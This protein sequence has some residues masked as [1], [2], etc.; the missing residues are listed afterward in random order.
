MVDFEQNF[1]ACHSKS[2]ISSTVMTFYYCCPN[3]VFSSI[4]FLL[5]PLSTVLAF[6][7]LSTAL[8]ICSKWSNIKYL[9][10]H[11]I[12]WYLSWIVFSYQVDFISR[13]A[14]LNCVLA[15]I[16]YYSCFIF[17]DTCITYNF[18]FYNNSP[19]IFIPNNLFSVFQMFPI[20]FPNTLFV[21]HFTTTTYFIPIF[22]SLSL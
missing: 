6:L 13:C 2:K 11:S 8:K 9:S 21:W 22:F 12:L 4:Y 18:C 16:L 17:P 15:N 10:L 14:L 19:S 5:Q 20:S 1:I 3:F 7:T